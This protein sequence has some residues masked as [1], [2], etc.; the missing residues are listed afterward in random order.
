MKGP[1]ET[2]FTDR[3]ST[4]AKAREA[5]LARAKAKSPQN[6]PEFAARQAMRME[7]EAARKARLEAREAE[8]RA[9]A[10]RIAA[11]KAAQEEARLE[12]LR[13]EE[14][15]KAAAKKAEL[16]KLADLLTAQKAARDARY[17]ARKSRRK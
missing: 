4:A 7:A 3:L 16:S 1:K 8:K 14:E 17:A 9:E 12:A 5:M 11:E 13:R 15:E 6:D 10:E 2:R